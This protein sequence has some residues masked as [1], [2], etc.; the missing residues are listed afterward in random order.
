MAEIILLRHGQASFGADNYDQLSETGFQQA[1]AL[2]SHWAALGKSV[3]RI[4]MGSLARHRQTAEGFLA[5]FGQSTQLETHAGFNEYHFNGL[6]EALKARFPEQWVDTG[7]A[8]RDYYHNMKSALLR[9]I[10]G[11]IR[12]D[13]R[14]TWTSFRERIRDAFTFAC[15][16]PGKRI[17]IVSSGGPLS[18]ILADILLLAAGPTV[19]LSLQIKNSSVSTLLYN[20]VNFTVDSINDVSHLLTTDKQ[21][22]ITFS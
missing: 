14:D 16:H 20:R 7:R 13:G 4:V 6:L 17:L 8:R 2:G 5:G 21:H 15:D 12:D 10:E 19:D 1:E 11:G 18:V 3:D 9:W 22:L